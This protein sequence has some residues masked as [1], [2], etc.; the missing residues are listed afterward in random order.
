MSGDFVTPSRSIFLIF[1]QMSKSHSP[2]WKK[3]LTLNNNNAINGEKNNRNQAGETKKR[4]SNRGDGSSSLRAQSKFDGAEGNE[5]TTAKGVL[6]SNESN[7]ER[8]ADP[9]RKI[10]GASDVQSKKPKKKSKAKSGESKGK[11]NVT[12]SEKLERLE[13]LIEKSEVTIPKE[14]PV[15]AKSGKVTFF[16]TVRC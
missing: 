7:D 5:A 4:F 2:N 12:S 9:R 16:F 6:K 15:A 14:A 3:F 8:E 1:W 10:D 11:V 13:S